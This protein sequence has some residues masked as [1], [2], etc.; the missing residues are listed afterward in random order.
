MKEQLIKLLNLSPESTDDQ[1]VAAVSKLKDSETL[2]RKEAA[3]L[4]ELVR[5]KSADLTT[6]IQTRVDPRVRQKMA[7][8]LSR[9]QAEEVIANQDREDKANKNK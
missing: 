3:G 5:T 8:G 2:L 4:Q 6:T 1:V 9:E 7:A